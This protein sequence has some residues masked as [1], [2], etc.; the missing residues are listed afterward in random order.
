MQHKHPPLPVKWYV[1]SLLGTICLAFVL[2]TVFEIRAGKDPRVVS[3]LNRPLDQRDPVARLSPASM[4]TRP[5]LQPQPA[6]AHIRQSSL[7]S[8]LV[9][10]P[11]VYGGV[12]IVGLSTL[13]LV[14]NV[15]VNRRRAL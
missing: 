8:M 13:Y 1:T 14:G 12:A 5:D 3:D 7:W 6:R 2:M 10:K 4:E 15:I 9:P 11:V